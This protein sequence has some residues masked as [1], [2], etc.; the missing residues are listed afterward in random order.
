MVLGMVQGMVQVLVGV[1]VMVQVKDLV[2]VVLRLR[3]RLH[4]LRGVYLH[5]RGVFLHLHLHL[6]LQ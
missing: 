3:P 5:H 1:R 4:R 6:A 2:M